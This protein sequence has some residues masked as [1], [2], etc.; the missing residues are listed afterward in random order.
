NQFGGQAKS[1]EWAKQ[2]LSR[3]SSEVTAS[4]V[5]GDAGAVVEKAVKEQE[6][7]LLIM[8]AFS[9]SPLRALLFGSKT[10]ELLRSS[11]IPILLLR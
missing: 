5:P 2:T 8:G 1:L 6:I 11:H 9:H 3:A 10:A 4:L 7:D